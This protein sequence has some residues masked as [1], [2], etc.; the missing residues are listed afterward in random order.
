MVKGS[1]IDYL[2]TSYFSKSIVTKF[3][4]SMFDVFQYSGVFFGLI[5]QI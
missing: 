4:K 2:E 3:T 1:L 5:G